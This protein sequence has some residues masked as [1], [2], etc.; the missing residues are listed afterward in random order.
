MAECTNINLSVDSDIDGFDDLCEYRLA[1]AF[2]PFLRVSADDADVSR[3]P[4]W[5]ATYRPQLYHP[6]ITHH[7]SIMYLLAYHTDYG[8][9]WTGHEGDSEFI[10]VD[11]LYNETTQHW[12]LWQAFLSAHWGGN[13]SLSDYVGFGSFEY[14]HHYRGYP[15]VYVSKNKH[16]NY[17]SKKRCDLLQ[18]TCPNMIDGGRVFVDQSRNIGSNQARLV[19]IVTSQQPYSYGGTEAF[20]TSNTFCGWWLGATDCAG[21]YKHA[22]AAYDF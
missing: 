10:I 17:E 8:A 19:N 6:G 3:E 12:E 15:K 18:D 4:Y 13:A 7:V 21:G 5:A 1:H 11:V 9:S 14:P 2:A 20:W 22:L 16:A